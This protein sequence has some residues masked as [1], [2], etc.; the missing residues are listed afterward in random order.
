[1]KPIRILGL[2]LLLAVGHC[3]ASPGNMCGETCTRMVHEAHALQGRGKYNEALDKF[4]A[5]SRAE[6]Q[7]SM[8]VSSEAALIL[9]LSSAVKPEQTAEFRAAAR[10]LARRALDLWPEDPLAHEVLRKLDDDAPSLLHEPNEKARGLLANAESQFMQQ[11]YMEALLQY[12]AAAQADPQLSSAWIGIGDCYFNQQDW[13]RAEAGFRRATEIEPRNS[14]AWRFL[15]DALILQG[16]RD[17]AESA[18]LS[19]VAADPAQRPNWIKLA[20]LRAG[21]SLPLQSLALRRG[22]RV[23]AKSGGGGTVVLDKSV[24]DKGNKADMAFRVMLGA[25]ETSM[26][27]GD[28][29]KPK[30]AYE[31][32][33]TAWRLALAS[34]DKPKDPAADKLSDPALLRMQALARDGQLEPAILLLQFRQAYRPALESWLAAHPGGVKAFIDRYG[35][36]P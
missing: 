16:K 8:P 30:S 18:L 24:V 20:A 1:M 15:A 17:A 28:G 35:L 5:A 23:E 21:D 9:T 36:Q 34:I 3:A 32:E 14:Q 4:R 19:G 10:G 2:S 22:V 33:L 29:A 31:I 13:P 12:E 11:H 26:R 27:F 7:A 25:V 6:P